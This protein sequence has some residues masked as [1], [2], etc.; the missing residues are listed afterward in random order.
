M[1]YH[2]LAGEHSPNGSPP[3]I[4]SRRAQNRKYRIL[5]KLTLG[6]Q[7]PLA[8]K[9]SLFHFQHSL[10]QS[11]SPDIH[12]IYFKLT[13]GLWTELARPFV[14]L[15][16]S[17][18]MNRVRSDESR[19]GRSLGCLALQTYFLSERDPQCPVSGTDC[20]S[21]NLAPRSGEKFQVSELGL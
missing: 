18:L 13:S 17:G 19:L 1:T 5:V 7:Q 21:F 10:N 20:G 3:R 14:C 8:Q 16:Y 2:L 12:P 4:S 9:S 6:S 11:Q 15:S